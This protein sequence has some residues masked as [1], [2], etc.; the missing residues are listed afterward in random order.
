MQTC[1]R[2]AESGAVVAENQI[3]SFMRSAGGFGE[4]PR[5]QRTPA[6]TARNEPSK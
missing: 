4:Q 2:C 1:S 5:A 6:A 3:T